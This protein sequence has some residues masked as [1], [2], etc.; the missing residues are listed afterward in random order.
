MIIGDTVRLRAIEKDDLLLF[1]RW[2]NDPEVRHGLMVFL[3][4]SL[5]EEQQ[6]Y[7]AMLK[8]PQEERPLM[9]EIDD[10]GKWVAV[11]NCG[12]FDINWRI[13]SAEVGICIGEKKYWNKGFGT[14]SMKLLLH[15][16]F[17]TL[18]LNR[19]ALHVYENNPRALRAYEKAGFTH[20]GRMR[21]AHF[22]DGQYFDAHLMSVL[23]SEWK[24]E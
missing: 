8:R 11:G 20:E 3:P 1:T 7:E 9:I 17:K 6:W 19:I 21:Q 5:T 13:R 24:D 18:N 16:G 12:L 4:L 14:K 10:G 15:H 22:Q 23:R 2:F